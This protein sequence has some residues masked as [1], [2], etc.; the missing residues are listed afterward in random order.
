MTVEAVLARLQGVRR[1]GNG[2]MA[3]C[4][5]H[6]DKN[7]SLSINE[8]KGK[9]LLKCFAG[10]TTEAV[11]AAT[12]IELSE[13]FN[14]NGAAPRIVAEYDYVDEAGVLLYIRFFAM[15]QRD[16]NSGVPMARAAG[17]GI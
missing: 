5:A 11:C 15:N 1:N 9:I 17:I 6:A 2:W 10:C 3:L 8:G 4:P 14:D 7:P 12:G 13:L 16:S